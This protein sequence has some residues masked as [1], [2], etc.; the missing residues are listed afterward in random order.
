M[1]ELYTNQHQPNYSKFRERSIC[2]KVFVSLENF[3]VFYIQY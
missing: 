2:N 1:L 3:T